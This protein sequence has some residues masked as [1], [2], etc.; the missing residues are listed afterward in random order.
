MQARLYDI[1]GYMG[2]QGR[3]RDSKSESQKIS[4]LSFLSKGS[5]LSFEQGDGWGYP[6]SLFRALYDS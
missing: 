5:F 3:E 1:H 4:F 6:V 2:I